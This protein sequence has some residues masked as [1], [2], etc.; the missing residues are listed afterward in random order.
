MKSNNTGTLFH[1]TKS[2]SNI[3]SILENGLQFSYCTEDFSQHTTIYNNKFGIPMVCFCDIPIT[4]A[5]EHTYRYGKYAIGI[6]K[7][8]LLNGEYKQSINPV[9]Y[10]FSESVLESVNYTQQI[11]LSNRPLL[12]RTIEVESKKGNIEVS[13]YDA[14][15]GNFGRIV[16]K[17]MVALG[18][19]APLQPIFDKLAID[20]Y[21]DI[22]YGFTKKY[23]GRDKDGGDV[24][25][26]NECEWRIVLIERGLVNDNCTWIRE[27]ALLSEFERWKADHMH[28]SHQIFSLNRF[29]KF[30]AQDITYIIVPTEKEVTKIVEFILNDSTKTIGGKSISKY[31]KELLISKIISIERIEQDF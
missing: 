26:Y 15:T 29:C 10:I 11:E 14:S 19:G 4:R 8:S 12:E 31:Q 25:N 5:T 17:G 28:I 18:D 7:K 2:L 21:L 9:M 13:D 30:S 22:I 27:S 3:T 23:I 20:A 24:I 16:F 6:S 1:Y